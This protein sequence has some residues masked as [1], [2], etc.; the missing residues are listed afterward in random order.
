MTAYDPNNESFLQEEATWTDQIFEIVNGYKVQAA[1][2][3]GSGDGFVN[4]QSRELAN[5]TLYLKGEIEQLIDDLAELGAEV[6][7]IDLSTL[8]DIRGGQLLN[9]AAGA[10][11]WAQPN[12]DGSGVTITPATAAGGALAAAALTYSTASQKWNFV[13]G[14]R[15]EGADVLTANHAALAASIGGTGYQKLPSG[16]IIQW[17]MATVAGDGLAYVTFPLAFTQ[18]CHFVCGSHVGGD[19]AMVSE[20]DGSRTTAGVQLVVRNPERSWTAGWPVNFL[21]IGK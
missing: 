7:D 3:R 17:G 14:V 2:S 8:F 6:D 19:I 21:A 11:L 20:V 4:R 16:L 10:K 15:S 13:G 9:G 5:R 18:A 1:T 12:G